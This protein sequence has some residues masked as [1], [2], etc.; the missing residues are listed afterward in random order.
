MHVAQVQSKKK[1]LLSLGY[2]A[3]KVNRLMKYWR[4]EIK[5]RGE[6]LTN[7]ETSKTLQQKDTLVYPACL[8]VLQS[9]NDK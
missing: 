6:E 5:T 4:N 8:Q 7:V 3:C 2:T 9:E 1:S